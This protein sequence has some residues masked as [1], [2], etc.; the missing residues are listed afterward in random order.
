METINFGEHFT[1]DGYGGDYDLLNDSNLVLGTLTE[2]PG[3]LRKNSIFDILH[4]NS[5]R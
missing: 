3:L 5:L 1:I 2:L 4:Q